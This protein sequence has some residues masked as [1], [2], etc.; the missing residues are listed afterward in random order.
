M[1]LL[2]WPDDVNDAV[3]E[4]QG[5]STD[6]DYV[7]Y[8]VSNPKSQ[9]PL[10]VLQSK[11]KG[12]RERV[13][14][15]LSSPENNDKVLTGAFMASG[16]DER[17]DIISIR[18]KFIHVTY[19]GA[20]VGVL[21]K[22]KVNT[23]S[24][25]FR[26]QF[27]N[28]MAMYLQLDADRLLDELDEKTLGASLIA[29]SGGDKPSRIDFT[30]G[31]E[32]AVKEKKAKSGLEDVLLP[33]DVAAPEEGTKETLE[34]EVNGVAKDDELEDDDQ[35][36]GQILCAEETEQASSEP[37]SFQDRM[38]AFHEN[39]SPDAFAKKNQNN[40]NKVASDELAQCH[41]AREK[42]KGRWGKIRTSLG[43]YQEPE[44]T[45]ETE[46]EPAADEGCLS[47][48]KLKN[49][50]WI[51]ND[52]KKVAHKGMSVP[53]DELAQCHAARERWGKTKTTPEQ[54]I[55][56][57]T[58]SDMPKLETNMLKDRMS[59]YGGGN[60]RSAI[61]TS[62]KE[63]KSKVLVDVSPH[64]PRG[65]LLP[66]NTVVWPENVTDMVKEIQDDN[67]NVDYILF[68]V[69]D[70]KKAVPELVL[71]SKGKGG[72]HAM[73]EILANND[74]RDMVVTGAFM[75]SA[76]DERGDVVSIRRKFVH[77]TYVGEAVSALAKGKVNS[78]S[79]SFRD[80]FPNI[81][82]YLQLNSD[83]LDELDEVSLEAS[84][85]AA[86]GG[87]KPSRI[88]FTNGGRSEKKGDRMSTY[89]RVSSAEYTSINKDVVS[90][91]PSLK[92]RV[93]ALKEASSP[94]ACSQR[95]LVDPREEIMGSPGAS[96]SDRVSALEV[97]SKT[98]D[99][100]GLPPPPPLSIEEMT[101][102]Q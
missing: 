47:P 50:P 75:V 36:E 74:V 101:K 79:G 9:S 39:T 100:L 80:P 26:E 7:L 95:K 72:R 13:A 22:G 10:M 68:A 94:N 46:P 4:L 58:P 38:K 65:K 61:S 32:L 102:G 97:S 23:W 86:S 29:S 83:R 28:N 34:E 92:D 35:K 19:V 37:E 62:K 30:N 91:G 17:G 51:K 84:L 41:A 1:V 5:K 3:S 85:I 55:Q 25:S 20:N 64:S 45:H 12:G 21:T 82:M 67:A 70:L 81:C 52:A 78:W 98:E 71:H 43:S 6:V 42:A 24:G 8:A 96:L 16:I 40:A 89:Q 14:E 48:S 57:R 60:E 76:V 27:G 56:A 59:A 33:V 99:K 77:V 31:S 18:R 66:S 73:S 53:S 54:E 88:D 63:I 11:G 69:S 44:K 2:Q 15:I 93:F 49:M 90:P 87:D